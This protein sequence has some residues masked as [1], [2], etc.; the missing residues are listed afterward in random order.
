[1]SWAI[2]ALKTRR[3]LSLWLYYQY[4]Q[5]KPTRQS[6]LNAL[7]V[8]NQW[9]G[10]SMAYWNKTTDRSKS[11]HCGNYHLFIAS[12]CQRAAYDHRTMQNNGLRRRR[13][14]KFRGVNWSHSYWPI[15]SMAQK[16]P[17]CE[18]TQYQIWSTLWLW[19]KFIFTAV[20]WWEFCLSVRLSIC[21]S[22]ACIVTKR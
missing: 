3:Q 4:R 11:V 12:L 13:E 15:R 18:K 16:W 8:A 2:N 19:L 17:W 6:Q 10:H 14:R 22:H 1:M 9:L 5:L 21:L 7:I 20:L